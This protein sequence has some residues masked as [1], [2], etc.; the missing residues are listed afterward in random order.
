[1]VAGF[2]TAVRALITNDITEIR[3]KQTVETT[4][5]L[6]CSAVVDTLIAISMT[7]LVT[8]VPIHSPG[9]VKKEIT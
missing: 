9:T 2:V 1:M 8:P 5:W 7:L 6:A 3:Q 4:L